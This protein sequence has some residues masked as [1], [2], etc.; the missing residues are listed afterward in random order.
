MEVGAKLPRLF[1]NRRRPATALC[2]LAAASVAA[3][4]PAFSCGAALHPM[5]KIELMFGRAVR[6][7]DGDAAW[8]RFVA[9][10][11]TP[12]FPDGLTVLDAA[13]QWRDA[14][15]DRLVRERS[16]LVIIVTPADAPVDAR[17]AAVVAAYKHQ[18]RQKSVGVVASPV[19]AAF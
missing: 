15:A 17:I 2:I 8:V 4:R 7:G 11:I 6:R 14:A 13:G 19:C 1:S 3:G 18:F 16:K 9:R 5:Q 10:E 12:R